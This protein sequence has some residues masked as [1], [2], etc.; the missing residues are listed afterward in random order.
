MKCLRAVKLM[1]SW[2]ACTLSVDDY[3]NDWKLEKHRITNMNY[4]RIGYVRTG[5]KHKQLYGTL[6]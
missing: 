4:V 3:K 5:T 2:N 6:F 1:S